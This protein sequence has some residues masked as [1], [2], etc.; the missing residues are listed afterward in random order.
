[1]VRLDYQEHGV[2]PRDEARFCVDGLPSCADG[3]ARYRQGG[4]RCAGAWLVDV[5]LD[6]ATAP[7]VEFCQ[8]GMAVVRH[9]E[10]EVSCCG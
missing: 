8:H 10:V 7:C 3:A 9:A 2:R 5:H 1:M 4:D 6:A